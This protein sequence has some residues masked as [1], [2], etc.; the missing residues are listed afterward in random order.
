MAALQRWSFL[1]RILVGTTLR[2]RLAYKWNFAVGLLLQMALNFSELAAI[3]L[4]IQR[5]HNIGGWD[6]YGLMILFGL[7]SASSGI[8]HIFASELNSF[9]KYLVDGQF[10]AIL[11]RPAPTL[12]TIAARSV[13]LEHSAIFLQ[14]VGVLAFVYIKKTAQLHFGVNTIVEMA[15]GIICGAF[16]WF[17]IVTA[18]ATLGFWTTQV[19]NLQPVLLYGPETASAYPLTIYP[20]AIQLVFYSILPTAFGAFIPASVILHKGVGDI[21]LVY[22]G[23][24]SLIAFAVAVWFWNFGV[25][26]Y[27]ST[28]T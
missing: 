18:T 9:D 24:V 4:I 16:I 7:M 23:L 27:T 28:G 22:C 19:D 17:S 5:V 14:G 15:V 3:L 20:K 13:D 1:Y 26:H 25:R 2:T 21:A 8:Y 10:D 6:A 12:L 11:T